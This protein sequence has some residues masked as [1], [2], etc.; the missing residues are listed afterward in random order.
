MDFGVLLMYAVG[1]FL[2]DLFC[3][4][5]RSERHG[6][7]LSAFLRG[8]TVY[9]VGEVLHQLDAVAG[10]FENSQEPLYALAPPYKSMRSGRATLTSYAAQKVRHQ[11]SVEQQAAVDPN[12]GLH[13]FSPHKKTEP[14]NL[15]L[16]WDTYGATTFEDVQAVLRRHQPLTFTLGTNPPVLSQYML[17][18]WWFHVQNTNTFL[19]QDMLSSFRIY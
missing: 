12:G 8:T 3:V 7:M 6:K 10:Q 13:V 18:T 5:G 1:D 2:M 4:T 14:I 19:N 9:G 15:R 17:S 11:L 16:S